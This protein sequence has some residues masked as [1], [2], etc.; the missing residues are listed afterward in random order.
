MWEYIHEGA[1][2]L[3]SAELSSFVV[4]IISVV[5]APNVYKYMTYGNITYSGN[6]ACEQV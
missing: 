4:G 1:K 3:L 2:Y 5:G 6:L